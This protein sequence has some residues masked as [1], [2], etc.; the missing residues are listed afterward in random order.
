MPSLNSEHVNENLIQSQAADTITN[1]INK[2][3]KHPKT[4]YK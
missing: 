2:Q 1:H 3:F 4:I